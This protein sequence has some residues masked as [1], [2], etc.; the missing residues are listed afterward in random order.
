VT[1]GRSPLGVHSGVLF[2]VVMLALYGTATAALYAA[3]SPQE[4]RDTMPMFLDGEDVDAMQWASANTPA[5][6]SFAVIGGVGEWFPLVAHRTS[7]IA[8]RGSEWSDERSMTRH[9]AIKNDLERC[10]SADCVSNTF[11]EASVAPDYV[12]LPRDGFGEDEIAVIRWRQLGESLQSDH[13]Y[14][15]AY[16]KGDVMIFEEK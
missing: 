3:D 12:Y 11:E 7:L 16:R 1:I 2:V 4:S 14:E 5:D 6:A 13:R 9:T 10:L 8:P 15:L